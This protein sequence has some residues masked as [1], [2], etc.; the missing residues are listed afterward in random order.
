MNNPEDVLAPVRP[1][2]WGEL[3][4][5]LGQPVARVQTTL[6]L[7]LDLLARMGYRLQRVRNPAPAPELPAWFIDREELFA[8]IEAAMIAVTKRR[9]DGEMISDQ[10]EA[11]EIQ[12]AVE[13]VLYRDA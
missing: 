9:I 4:E 7:Y 1:S 2:H 3:A 11:R 12:S 13:E 8:A 6:R 10:A 5:Q